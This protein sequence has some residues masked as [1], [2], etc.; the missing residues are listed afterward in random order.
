MNAATLWQPF[1]GPG[2][3]FNDLDSV[4][5]GNGQTATN[6]TAITGVSQRYDGLTLPGRET[7]LSLWSLA[8]SP[9]ILGSDLATLNRTQN[10]VDLA[11]LLNRKVLAVDQDKIP[12][13]RIAITPIDQVFT[14]TER[15]GDV[16]VGLFNTDYSQPQVITTSAAKLACVVRRNV[17]R[18]RPMGAQQRSLRSSVSA[19]CQPDAGVCHD[20]PLRGRHSDQLRDWRRD[21]CQRPSRGGGPVRRHAAPPSSAAVGGSA[22]RPASSEHH[23]KPRRESPG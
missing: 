10:P 22:S 20:A 11:L 7:V 1:A 15:D 8:S 17:P 2:K 3:G 12:A 23:T 6:P 13:S 18:A 4:E 14:K 16:I 19:E 21:Q 9:L 5:V